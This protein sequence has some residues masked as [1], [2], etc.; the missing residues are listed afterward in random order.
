MMFRCGFCGVALTLVI[1]SATVLSDDDPLF[2]SQTID[3]SA[4]AGILLSDDGEH[5]FGLLRANMIHPG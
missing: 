3:E 4:F 1:A 5:H 2:A